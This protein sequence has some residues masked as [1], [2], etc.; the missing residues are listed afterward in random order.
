MKSKS[1]SLTLLTVTSIALLGACSGK[2][3]A[4][5]RVVSF[6]KE[7]APIIQKNCLECHMP[8]GPGEKASGLLMSSE[9]KPAEVNYD[10]LMKGTRFGSIIVPG[11]STSSTLNRLVEGRADPSLRMPHGKEELSDADKLTLR[12][13]VDQGA[14]NN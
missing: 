8:N 1:L 13:W 5:E 3:E 10:N 6:S 4:P 12:L 7:V 9:E 11:D 14:K 2:Q